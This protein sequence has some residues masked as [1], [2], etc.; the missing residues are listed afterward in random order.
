MATMLALAARG[1][2][3]QPAV[4]P[5]R[6]LTRRWESTQPAPSSTPSSHTAAAASTP[7]P[8][9]RSGG[10]S[11]NSGGSSGRSSTHRR[12]NRRTLLGLAAFATLGFSFPFWLWWRN[13]ERHY[14]GSR[15]LSPSAS[16]RGAYVN[17]STKDIGPDRGY[18]QHF[19]IQP[20]ESKQYKANMQ[21]Q[22]QQQQPHDNHG[23]GDISNNSSSNNSSG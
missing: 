7:V 12:S 16:I 13:T 19:H 2:R 17:S 11:N 5:L 21:K 4:A 1:S 18:Q 23:S 22:K 20:V 8:P 9:A 15:A 6:S 3:T 14:T 10:S